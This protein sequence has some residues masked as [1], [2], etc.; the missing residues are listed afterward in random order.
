MSWLYTAVKD[1]KIHYS[2]KELAYD[3]LD[4]VG[5]DQETYVDLKQI[6]EGLIELPGPVLMDRTYQS[7]KIEDFKLK[8]PTSDFEYFYFKL[9]ESPLR[10]FKSGNEYYKLH[11]WMTCVMFT[12][13]QGNTIKEVM[14]KNLDE[15]SA[16][17]T[18]ETLKL[19][20]G[21][22]EFNKQNNSKKLGN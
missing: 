10:K 17:A 2:N 11:G 12:K 9:E 16:L 14:H 21:L 1:L 15:I 20:K 19:Q 18:E 3:L 22:M 13:E 5:I 6:N 8:I 4:E 7:I